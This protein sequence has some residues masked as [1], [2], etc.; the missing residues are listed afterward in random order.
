MDALK[1][2]DDRIRAADSTL[3]K[4]IELKSGLMQDLLTGRVPV[5][6]LLESEP[7]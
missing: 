5:D 2:A 3:A 4:L 6:A 7:A 1:A